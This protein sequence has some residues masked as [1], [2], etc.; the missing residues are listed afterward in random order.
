M[1]FAEPW[2]AQAYALAVQ[3]SERGLLD[4]S[5]WTSRG[6]SLEALEHVAG[7]LAGPETLEAHREAWARAAARTPH[8]QPIELTPADFR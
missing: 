8:G 4:L 7:D 3:L 5:E 1:N 6:G 2:Q